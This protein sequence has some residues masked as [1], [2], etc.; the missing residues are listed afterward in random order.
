MS[1]GGQPLLAHRRQ[2][3]RIYSH[4]LKY[5]N[6][7]I[8]LLFLAAK[9]LKSEGKSETRVFPKNGPLMGEHRY[10][11]IQ[12]HERFAAQDCSGR[13]ITA[14]L[15]SAIPA[16]PPESIFSM[17]AGGIISATDREDSKSR[18][19]RSIA[20]S[21]HGESFSTFIEWLGLFSY[22]KQSAPNSL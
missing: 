7:F 5:F 21:Q 14:F 12:T 9:L 19:F 4:K 18:H 13:G 10:E 2:N 6:Q 8:W 16:F 15:D 11:S 22:L 17:S 3:N 20:A 1:A